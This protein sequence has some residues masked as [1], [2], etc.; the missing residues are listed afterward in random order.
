[1]KMMMIAIAMTQAALV[2]MV[3]ALSVTRSGHV[4]R[5]WV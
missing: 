2:M 3:S 4:I 1:M 5:Q